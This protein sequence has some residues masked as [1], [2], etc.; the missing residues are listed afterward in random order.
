MSTHPEHILQL[1]AYWRSLAA[2]RAPARQQID[3]TAIKELLPYLLLAGFEEMPFRVRFR[4]TGTVVDQMTGM[5]IT[6]RYL[7]EFAAGIY[8]T[9]VLQLQAHYRQVWETGQPIIDTYHWPVSDHYFLDVS[10]GLFPLLIG[11]T[12]GQC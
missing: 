2:G 7:D 1:Q 11:D 10:Y 12:V 5:N 4:L 8:K 3:P 9:P 6:G